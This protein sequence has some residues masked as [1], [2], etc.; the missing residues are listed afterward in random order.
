MENN[1]PTETFLRAI[2]VH[3]L[4]PQQEPFVM[5]GSIVHY[6]EECTETETLIKSDNIFVD[7]GEMSTAGMIENIAQTC[8]ARIGYEN[9]YIKGEG[10][11]IGVIGAVRKLKVRE[12]PK[13]G[14]VI[15]TRIEIIEVLLGMTLAMATI[16]CGGEL[17]AKGQIKLAVKED[18]QA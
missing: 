9:K 4:L 11:Q 5:I 18:N 2:D 10:V 15:T 12:H 7:D 1:K 6:D 3:T 13:A 14:S 17:M 16:T 8:A